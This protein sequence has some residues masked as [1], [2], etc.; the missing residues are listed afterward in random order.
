M[1]IIALLATFNEQRFIG[2]CLEHLARHG[3]DAYIIDND[4]TDDTVAIVQQFAGRNLVGIEQ[5]PRHGTY[6]WRAI[7]ERKA[8]LAAELDADWFIHADPDETRLPPGPQHTLAEALAEADAAGYNAVNFM[9]FTFV[10]TRQSPD[11]N[12]ADYLRTMRWYYPFLPEFPHRLTAWK[13]Q[14]EL[15][16]LG[17]TGG[18]RVAFPGL[19]MYPTS[20]PMRHYLFLSPAHAIEKHVRRVYDPAELA[21]GWHRARA[22]LT[23]EGIV[24]QDESALRVYEGDDQLDATQPL[25]AHPLF[26]N[27]P[28]AAAPGS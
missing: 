22:R 15:V 20:F 17:S 1:R 6:V 23:A 24:L 13:K 14:T 21:V 5:L 16:D 19:R 8:A 9:E 26:S 10:P 4:S 28:A 25:K 27:F 12:H 7:L 11:H 3:I 2:D 18:H